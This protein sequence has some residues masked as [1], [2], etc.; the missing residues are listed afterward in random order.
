MIWHVPTNKEDCVRASRLKGNRLLLVFDNRYNTDGINN[1]S[2][3]RLKWIQNLGPV[4][5][6]KVETDSESVAQSGILSELASKV[7]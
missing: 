2:Y 4:R 5:E 1:G 7:E 6:S 3:R